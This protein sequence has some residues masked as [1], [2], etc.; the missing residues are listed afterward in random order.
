MFEAKLDTEFARWD[1][2]GS[3]LGNYAD[4]NNDFSKVNTVKFKIGAQVSNEVV[5]K[6]FVLVMKK[7]NVLKRTYDKYSN[8]EI[9]YTGAATF[10]YTLSIDA[11]KDDGGYVAIKRFNFEKL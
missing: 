8:P 2:Y 6:P 1:D 10:E 3:Y 11:F 9:S 4:Y 7:E 5:K